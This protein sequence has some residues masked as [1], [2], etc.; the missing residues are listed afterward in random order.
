LESTKAL[1]ITLMLPCHPNSELRRPWKLWR[2]SSIG[3]IDKNS[4]RSSNIW[5]TSREHEVFGMH[6]MQ[7]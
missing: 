4:E 1:E 5:L 3:T 7:D 2:K 6:S